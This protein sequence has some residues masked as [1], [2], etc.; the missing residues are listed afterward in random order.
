[1]LSQAGKPAFQIVEDTGIILDDRL[2]QLHSLWLA[3][4]FDGRPPPRAFIDPIAL[5]FVI[6]SL[7][8]FEVAEPGPR[9]RY[10][11]VGTDVVDHLGMELTGLWLED[12]P[13]HDRLGDIIQVLTL[14]W[15]TGQAVS[16]HYKL[17]LFDEKWRCESLV[18]PILDTP[19][20]MPVILAAQIFPSTM[21]R[22]RRS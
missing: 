15:Q 5:R 7:L 1:M 10:R 8:L 6:G 19:G 17:K 22:W 21:P 3:A 11:L 9:Y 2:R 18:L 20:E 13:D 12:H 16:F 14:A 4:H